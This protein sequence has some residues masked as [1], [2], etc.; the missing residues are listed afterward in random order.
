MEPQYTLSDIFKHENTIRQYC[1]SEDQIDLPSE[2]LIYLA[3]L[4]PNFDTHFTEY[5]IFKR[6]HQ[7]AEYIFS[8][9]KKKGYLI[10]VRHYQNLKEDLDNNNTSKE[11]YEGWFKRYENSSIEEDDPLIPIINQAI[12]DNHWNFLYYLY[13]KKEKKLNDLL[14]ELK[15]QFNNKKFFIIQ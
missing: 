10:N 3:S 9:A 12:R 11:Y 6:L 1:F 2:K 13:Y 8:E 14:T 4:E 15:N 5:V 7:I